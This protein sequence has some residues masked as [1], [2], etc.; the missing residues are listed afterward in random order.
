MHNREKAVVEN[1]DKGFGILGLGLG[2][3]SFG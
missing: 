1:G 3:K 2:K